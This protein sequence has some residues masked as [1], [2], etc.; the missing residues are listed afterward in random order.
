MALDNAIAGT[1]TVSLEDRYT[2]TKEALQARGQGHLL[3]WWDELDADAR[4]ELFDEIDSIP[5]EL[6]DG[7]VE[8]HVL[9]KPEDAI[10]RDLEPAPMFRRVPEHDQREMYERAIA[11]GR[12]LIA[13]GKVAAFTVAGGQGTRLGFDGPKG[14]V[15]V[16]PV[17]EKTLFELFAEMVAAAR[18]KHDASIPWYIMTNPDNHEQTIEFFGDHDFFGLPEEDVMFFTQGMLPSFDFSAKVLLAEKGRVA[19]SPDGHGGS[20]KALAASGALADMQARGVEI[21]SYFQVDNPLVHPF[22][23]LFIGLHRQ[24]GSE[25]S[26]KVTPKSDDTEHVGNV[27]LADGRVSVIEYSNL[28]EEMAR[29]KNADGSRKFD[30]ANL[31]I[32]LLDVEF[33]DRIVGRDFTLPFHRAEKAVAYIDEAGEVQSPDEPNAVKLETFVFDALP[34]AANPLVFD[35]DREEEFAPVK[36]ATGADSLATSRAGQIRRA[37]RW[38]EQ[39][40]VKIPYDINGEPAVKIEIAPSY[41]MTADDVRSKAA[42]LPTLKPGE[43]VYLS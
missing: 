1:K 15:A 30:L 12:D 7:L 3:R 35:V 18:R 34:L 22:D 16:T 13:G 28:P 27:C 17:K 23:E 9:N 29:A 24:T 4:A 26:T 6:V 38:L 41:A 10:P 33:I 8:S 40:G 43:S 20:L 2:R 37:A 5:W 42:D 36:N 31:A 39:A 32:H 25:M 19:L 14:A 11:L 21:V